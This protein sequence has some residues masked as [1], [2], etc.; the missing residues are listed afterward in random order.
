M[1][2]GGVILLI[3]AVLVSSDPAGMVLMGIAGLLLLGF[4]SY[5]LLIYPRLVVT[6]APPRVTVRPIGGSHTYDV[7]QIDRIRLRSFRRI[8]RRVHQ[9]EFDVLP[10]GAISEPGRL[11]EDAR[12]VVFSRWDLGVDLTEVAGV[13]RDAGFV[14]DDER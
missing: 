7:T 8:G 5:A 1:A 9:L 3:A 2:A 10:P 12:L 14:V 11:H 13:L 6:A 4:A